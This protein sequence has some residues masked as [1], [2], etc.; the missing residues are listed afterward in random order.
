MTMYPTFRYQSAGDIPTFTL[1][2]QNRSDHAI[3]FVPEQIDASIDDR[4]AHVYT[5]EERVGEIRRSARRRQIALAIA[6]GLAAGAS[7]YAASHQTTTYSSYGFVGNRHPGGA[8]SGGD[9]LHTIQLQ[10]LM[11]ERGFTASQREVCRSVK[12]GAL[13]PVSPGPENSYA[14]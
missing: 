13:G 7:A 3:D 9:H 10:R 5:L 6:G 4:A 1:M 2:V 8:E 14:D 12:T 11:D